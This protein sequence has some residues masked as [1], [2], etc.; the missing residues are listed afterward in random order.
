MLWA[1]PRT[2]EGQMR[3]AVRIETRLLETA[4]ASGQH[5][6][7][8]SQALDAWAYE[9][10]VVLDFIQ[11]GNRSRTRCWR[12]TTG[13]CGTSC[14]TCR[15]IDEARSAVAEYREDGGYAGELKGA[16]NGTTCPVSWRSGR[17]TDFAGGVGETWP[18]WGITD[19]SRRGS[20]PGLECASL[21]AST[22]SDSTAGSHPAD[23]PP[24]GGY[25]GD[26]RVKSPADLRAR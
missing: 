21:R 12:A 20:R 8:R 25:Q 24:G 4:D 5:V 10:R 6:S 14:S 23:E 3:I 7:S 1:D 16:K 9:R 17:A 13:G 22:V 18:L 2:P 11:P 26:V 19:R 15:T